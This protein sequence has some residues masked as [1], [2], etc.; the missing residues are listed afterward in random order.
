MNGHSFGDELKMVT[1]G[2][3]CVWDI[4]G[5]GMMCV[6]V[7]PFALFM[8]GGLYTLSFIKRSDICGSLWQFTPEKKNTLRCSSRVNTLSFRR[9]FRMVATSCRQG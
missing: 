8:H 7:V 1:A 4:D 2:R 3:E 6:T 9:K 5:D